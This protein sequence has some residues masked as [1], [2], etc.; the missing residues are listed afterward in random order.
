MIPQSQSAHFL[1]PLYGIFWQSFVEYADTLVNVDLAVDG[2]R[3]EQ[4]SFGAE[5]KTTEDNPYVFWVNNDRDSGNDDEA[6]DE[7]PDTLNFNA[8]T[9]NIDNIRDLEDFTR[10][11]LDVET[12]KDP[13]I[14]EK[15]RIGFKWRNTTDSPAIRIFKTPNNDGSLDYL[16]DEAAAKLQADIDIPPLTSN[17]DRHSTPLMLEIKDNLEIFI[18]Q[19]YWGQAEAQ[20]EWERHFIFEGTDIGKGELVVIMQ[21]KDSN[22]NWGSTNELNSLWLDLKDVKKMYQHFTVGDSESANPSTSASEINSVS[23]S[24]LA[25]LKQE[26]DY[27]LFVHGWRMKT[28]ERR[29]FG[30]TA[31]KRLYW[32]GYK[33]RFGLFTWP[34]EW[35]SR[36]VGTAITDT[37]NYMRSDEKAMKS[38]QGLASLMNSLN[39]TYSGN[40]KVFAHS[41]GN[42]AVSEALRQG[43]TANTYIACQA[44]SVARAYDANGPEHLTPE[45]INEALLGKS[46]GIGNLAAWLASIETDQPDVF[47]NYPL[48][49]QPYYKGIKSNA[50]IIINHHNR[51]DDALAW[52]LAGQAEKPNENYRYR[53][54]IVGDPSSPPAAW[55][56]G[57]RGIH[58]AFIFE[59]ELTFPADTHE[60]FAR[61]AEPD[62]VPLGAS[63]TDG[64]S[65]GGEITDNL[66]LNDSS[67]YDFQ[68]G[69]E[70]HSAQFRSTIQRRSVY[71]KQ[72]LEDFGIIP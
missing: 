7:L 50:P 20:N 38:G 72:L 23:A 52:W 70:D 37:E 69:D 65:T 10:L 36:P 64:Y 18:P 49:G 17:E 48:T 40:L 63:V 56:K 11:W 28:W 22:G 57:S 32:E 2:D 51:L 5:D 43:G 61:A 29:A 21:S 33:G 34:T 66:N 35:T 25:N 58:N 3:N 71:W 6:E 39:S 1:N 19:Y 42:V 41:M 26:E 55:E 27:I 4:I 62:S 13:L 54:Q 60:I 16:F 44:A 24:D 12:F 53:T 8:K 68:D 45:R 46:Y 59:R 67:S 30:E 14:N 9:A 15:M 47:A 31:F